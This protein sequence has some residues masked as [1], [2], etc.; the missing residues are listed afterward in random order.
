[1]NNANSWN[2]E[3]KSAYLYAILS[4]R[5]PRQDIA[6]LFRKLGEEAER[7]ASIWAE[8]Q[9]KN[10]HPVPKEFHPDLRTRL[11]ARLLE[12]FQPRHLR[13]VL[14]AM[15]IR[16]L[17]AYT[18]DAPGHP[19]PTDVEQVGRRHRGAGV[20][21]NL[22]AA[23]FGV[24]D[25]LVSNASLILGVAGASHDKFFIL[26]SGIAG[27]L[28]GAFSMGAGEFISVK[29]QREMFEHQIDLEKKEL[30]QYPEEEA[31]ELALIYQTKGLELE[32]AR[33]LA[34][35]I[36]S[37][38]ARAL[39]TLAREELGLNLD[40]LGSPYGAALFSFLSFSGGA[41]IPLL[42]F[43]FAKHPNSLWISIGVTALALFGVGATLSLFTGRRALW[44]GLRMLLIGGMAGLATY[45]IGRLLGVT[46]S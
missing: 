19:M 15:K 37:N 33:R 34:H 22:R 8:Q 30:Q 38:P 26:L 40:E 45:V 31:E 17:S 13:M 6:Q 4:R 23:V 41:L 36:V 21:G 16:G 9:A 11:V 27:L 14:A 5:E 39:D 44:S 18:K 32:E 29:S 28:A 24:N 46:L 12:R 42:P 2:A 20:G 7:Q 10:G 3:K 35:K 43:L 25:G 1:M